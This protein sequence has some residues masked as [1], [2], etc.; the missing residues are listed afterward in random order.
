MFA[1]VRGAELK[2]V[3]RNAGGVLRAATQV[4][5]TGLLCAESHIDAPGEGYEFVKERDPIG[6]AV[7]DYLNDREDHLLV[8]WKNANRMQANRMIR[9]RLGHEG[10]LPDDGEPVLIRRNGGGF[11]NGEIVECGGFE[12]GPKVGSMRTLWMKV[13]TGDFQQRLLI[14]FEGGRDGEMFDGQMPW[15]E[16]W[17]QYHADLRRLKLDA[18]TPVTWGYC[19]TAHSAQ[20]SEARRATVFLAHGDERN[21]NFNKETT[22]PSGEKA[23]FSARFL[24][25]A[26]TRGKKSSQLIIAQ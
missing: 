1:H 21:R 9:E 7:D 22:L 16:D 10:P 2:T 11:L 13:G 19:L 26:L 18:P 6:R 23:R 12:T 14:S 4:R 8:T 5:E 24:Y 25:T 15:L 20:G 3:L 17:R